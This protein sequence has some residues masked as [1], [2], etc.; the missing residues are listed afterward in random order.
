LLHFAGRTERD[1]QAARRRGDGGKCVRDEA[2]SQYR[3]P[4]MQLEPLLAYLKGHFPLHDVEPFL[5]IQVQMQR[6][7]PRK[8]MGLLHDSGEVGPLAA[9]L[10]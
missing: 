5:L 1:Q 8:V 7:S 2:G 10:C 6:R 9:L 4:R 3:F